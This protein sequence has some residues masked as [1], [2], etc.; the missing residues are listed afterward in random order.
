MTTPRIAGIGSDYFEAAPDESLQDFRAR[1][2]QLAKARGSKIVVLGHEDNGK[3]P[4]SMPVRPH[5]Q[6]ERARPAQ[7]KKNQ[8]Q[9][10]NRNSNNNHADNRLDRHRYDSGTCQAD[11]SETAESK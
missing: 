1:L 11:A 9:N 3:P 8:D 10:R 6:V 5:P 7:P 2:K 4:R